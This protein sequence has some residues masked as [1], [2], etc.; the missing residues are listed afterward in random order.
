MVNTNLRSGYRFSG[1]ITIMLSGNQILTY[2][3]KIK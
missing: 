1:G 3:P 2:N